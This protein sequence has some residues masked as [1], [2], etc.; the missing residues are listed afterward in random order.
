MP[1]MPGSSLAGRL[2]LHSGD[3]TR[4]QRTIDPL[5][6]SVLFVLLLGEKAWN[7]PNLQLQPWI[8]VFACTA[9]LLPRSGV[10]GSVRN[11]SLLLLARR[12]LSSWLLVCTAVLGLSFV[13]KTTT[14]FSR[15]EVGTWAVLS[16]LLLLLN[17][18]GLRLLLRRH[19]SRGGNSRS[20][21][22]WG[23]A[24]GAVAFNSELL[25]NAW[26][27]LQLVAWFGPQAP[28]LGTNTS[29]LLS[30]GGG[31]S[32]M[33]RWLDCNAVDRIVFSHV[34]RNGVEMADVLKMFGDTCVP[35]IYAPHWAHP[36]MRFKVDYVGEQCCINLWGGE[37]L[38]S[39]RQLK[40]CFDLLLSVAGLLLIS[41]LLLAIA[42]AV[43]LSGP[44]SIL[45][46]QDRYGLDGRSF[47]IY[48]FRTMRVMEAG[49][50]PGLRQ[51]SRDDP[52]V[53]AVG[54]VLRCWSLDELPQLFNVLR[55]E[56]SL[57]GPRPHAVEHNEQYR[58]QIPGYMQR[59]SFKPGITGLAQIEGWR[60]ETSSLQSMVHRIEADL[61]YARDWSLKLDIKILLKTMLRLRSPNAY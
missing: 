37:R 12:V 34:T 29:N 24:E 36:S 46:V 48:K 23:T 9:I 43:R 17:H 56:M 58:R 54:R 25:A 57:V 31:L 53:T 55:G 13:S 51:A 60:G 18:V 2:R 30:W 35:V 40:R 11:T 1:L 5:L 39:D 8:W 49:D 16:L 15:S 3:L 47:R 61:R 41:P 6:V 32:D 45:F 50:T 10:Y 7:L 59:H 19:R 33:R 42:I 52:R 26:M 20:V 38:V 44:G 4:F 21:L 14:N 27:G 28:Q 22:Y